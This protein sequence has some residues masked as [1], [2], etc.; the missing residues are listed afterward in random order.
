MAS[1]KQINSKPYEWGQGAQAEA[2]GKASS[3]IFALGNKDRPRLCWWSQLGRPG[4][5]N[6]KGNRIRGI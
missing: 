3:V 1:G 4:K 5:E 2:V 6:D